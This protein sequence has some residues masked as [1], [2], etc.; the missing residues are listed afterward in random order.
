MDSREMYNATNHLTTLVTW[1][2]DWVHF[3]TEDE[4]KFDLVKTLIKDHLNDNELL[5]IHHRTNSGQ[6]NHKIIIDSITHLLGK[7]D[8]LLWTTTMDKVIE[9]NKIGVLRLGQKK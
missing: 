7:E 1:D 8:F 2:K 4:V 6:Y 5:F 3:G 9:F